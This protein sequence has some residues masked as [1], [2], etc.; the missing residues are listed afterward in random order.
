M[1]DRGGEDLFSSEK[2]GVLEL[3]DFIPTS[4]EIFSV[5]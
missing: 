4:R 5:L 3:V 2:R 1:P